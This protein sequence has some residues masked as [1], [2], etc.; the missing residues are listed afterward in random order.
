MAENIARRGFLQRASA[1][2][3]A[4]AAVAVGGAGLFGGAGTADRSPARPA[5]GASDADAASL[6]GAGLI[7]QVIDAR[8]GEI[9]ILVGTREIKYTDRE[10]AQR[11]LTAAQ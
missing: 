3:V 9:S 10:M 7:A 8:K 6:E 4:V 2:T 1:G 5:S 11:L